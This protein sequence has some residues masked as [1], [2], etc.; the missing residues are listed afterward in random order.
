MLLSKLATGHH[1]HS[2]A[3][4]RAMFASNPEKAEEIAHKEKEHGRL[5]R[6]P[7]KKDPSETIP[8]SQYGEI[9]KK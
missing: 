8:P 4:M 5:K 7:E 3:Q 2:K 6:L 1:I 9:L